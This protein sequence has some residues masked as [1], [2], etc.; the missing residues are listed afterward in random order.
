MASVL[1]SPDVTFHLALDTAKVY[2]TI[3]Y[4]ESVNPW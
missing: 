4:L 1:T 2:K 3:E